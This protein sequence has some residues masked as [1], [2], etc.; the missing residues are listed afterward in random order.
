MKKV[1][2]LPGEWY[3]VTAAAGTTVT[4]SPDGGKPVTLLTM[5]EAGQ[6]S[7]LAIDNEIVISDDD[8]IVLPTDAPAAGVSG[9]GGNDKQ[10]RADFEAH[11]ADEHIHLSAD[12]Q[13]QLDYLIRNY[14]RVP[15]T[16]L[17]QPSDNPG[18]EGDWSYLA[19]ADLSAYLSESLLLKPDGTLPVYACLF[20]WYQQTNSSAWSSAK[21][22]AQYLPDWC[23]GTP[24]LF[25]CLK[26][27]GTPKQWKPSTAFE[28]AIDEYQGEH[29]FNWWNVNYIRCNN[30]NRRITAVEG[31]DTYRE[32]GEVDVGVMYASR[33]CFFDCVE[34]PWNGSTRKYLL[35]VI[36]GGQMS[37]TRF[38]AAYKARLLEMGVTELKLFKECQRYNGANFDVTAAPYG[39]H[40]KYFCVLGGNGTT[41]LKPRSQRGHILTNVS[42]NQHVTGVSVTDGATGKKGVTNFGSKGA[43]YMGSGMDRNLFLILHLMIKSGTKNLQSFM[44]GQVNALKDGVPCQLGSSSAAQV[45]SPDSSSPLIAPGSSVLVTKGAESGFLVNDFVSV[46]GNNQRDFGQTHQARGRIIG[47]YDHIHPDTQVAY[48]EIVLELQ[49]GK[50]SFTYTTSHYVTQQLAPSGVTDLVVGRYDGSP[51]N[52]TGNHATPCRVMGTEYGVGALQIFMDATLEYQPGNLM[53]LWYASPQTPRQTETEFIRSTYADIGT[54]GKSGNYYAAD[55]L[56]DIETGTYRQTAPV[57]GSG[58]TTTGFCDQTVKETSATSG[59][60]AYWAYG[61]VDWLTGGASGLFGCNVGYGYYVA[62]LTTGYWFTA[63]CD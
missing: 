8:A 25:D 51:Y 32:E 16:P 29:L 27:D 46:G 57:S 21:C 1:N 23:N 61:S 42:H 6:A 11:A 17:P 2:T 40:S 26:S 60:R 28:A 44:T 36:A 63:A 30:G 49:Y 18:E 43:G 59:M 41:G 15:Q 31:M 52:L 45:F 22:E 7:F 39:V 3:C 53:R 54:V 34:L 56:V 50:T 5:E 13:G 19:D 58:S 35:V 33:W 47:F 9:G 62:Y 24:W 20:P 4:A 48:T 38:P 37:D 14:G 55:A 12:A 10:L